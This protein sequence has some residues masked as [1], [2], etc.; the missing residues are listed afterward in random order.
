MDR[1]RVTGP[2]SSVP[3][4]F[5]NAINEQTIVNSDKKRLDTRS[6][7]DLRPICKLHLIALLLST[8]I[9]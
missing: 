1:K 8:L 3:P 5:K 4:I 2:E 7:E 6:F 9:D